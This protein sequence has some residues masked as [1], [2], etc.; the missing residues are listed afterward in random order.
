MDKDIRTLESNHTWILTKLPAGKSVIGSKW[1]YKINRNHDGSV[2]IFN[3]RLVS[4]W[5]L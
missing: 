2:K 3:T 4:K 5:F 1:V